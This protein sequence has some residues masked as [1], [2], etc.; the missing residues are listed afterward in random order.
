MVTAF[1]LLQLGCARWA[2][3]SILQR[4]KSSKAHPFVSGAVQQFA[5]GMCL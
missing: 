3:G 1:L 4:K 2:L 5:T